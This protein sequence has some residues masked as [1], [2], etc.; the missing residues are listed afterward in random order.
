MNDDN[1][2]RA[3]YYGSLWEANI[4]LVDV[5][6][7]VHINRGICPSYAL[8][9]TDHAV[10]ADSCMIAILWQGQRRRESRESKCS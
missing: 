2:S 3:S 1:V 4:V 6:Q 10:Q 8:Q 7:C 5:I 9:R